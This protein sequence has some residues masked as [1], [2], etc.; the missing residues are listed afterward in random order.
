MNPTTWKTIKET[1]ATALELPLPDRESFLLK[2]NEEIRREVEKLL[3]TYTEA[4]TF[5]GTP[6]IVEQGLRHN[7]LEEN[8]TGKKIDDYF[9]LD[10]LGEGG[11]GAVFLAEHC[12]QGFSQR[13]ALKLIK[14]G[15]DTNAVL[16][17]F[18]MER[19]ILAN[20][21]HPNIARLYGGGST[22]D[23]LPYFVMEYVEGESIRDFCDNQQFDIN[24]RLRLLP[25][26]VKQFLMRINS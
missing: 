24:D 4:Q 6:L 3:S 18:L 16:G 23:G 7:P 20:L 1:F 14:R 25:R 9:V 2:S 12:G 8:L 26:S 5:I 15:M 17:R 22:T 21:E 19:Q 13:V 11:M 10:K